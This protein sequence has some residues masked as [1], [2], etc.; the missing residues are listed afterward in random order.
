MSVLSSISWKEKFQYWRPAWMSFLVFVAFDLVLR[1]ILPST[2]QLSFFSALLGT[3]VSLSFWSFWTVV[4]RLLPRRLA[5]VLAFL[6]GLSQACLLI[7]SYFTLSM[8]R[9]YVN[10]YMLMFVT[11]DRGF[12]SDQIWIYGLTPM[13]LGLIPVLVFFIWIWRP[14]PPSAKP[15]PVWVRTVKPAGLMVFF[16]VLFLVALNQVKYETVGQHKWADASFFLALKNYQKSNRLNVLRSSVRAKVTPLTTGRRPDILLFLG[17]SW[18][19]QMMT[20]YGWPTEASP[21]ITR[22][23]EGADSVVMKNAL[24]NSSCTDVSLPSLFAGVGPEE[25]D[26]KLHDMPLIWDW[27]RAAGYTTIFASPQKFAFANFDAFMLS[28]GPDDYLSA[29]R[30]M[31]LTQFMVAHNNGLDDIWAAARTKERIEQ[32]PKDK[33]LLL[34]FFTNATHYPFLQTSSELKEQPKFARPYENSLW[35]DDQAFAVLLEGFRSSRNLTKLWVLTSNDHG[36]LE[37]HVRP[38]PRIASFYDEILGSPMMSRFPSEMSVRWD[39]CQ[40]GFQMNQNRLIQNLDLLPTILDYVGFSESP[41]HQIL[42]S[43]LKGSSLCRPVDPGRVVVGLNTNN[44]RQW[45]PEGFLLA[46]DRWRLVFTNREGLQ[47]FDLRQDPDQ[48]Q[49]RLDEMP[50][51]L[52]EEFRRVVRENLQLQRIQNLYLKEGF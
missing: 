44:I 6:F 28:P 12:I 35:I 24:S 39:E 51:P 13:S 15:G 50:A 27:L 26:Q 41:A 7:A 17:E 25:S 29:D 40:K 21:Q 11:V 47:Y 1:S 16:V 46:K 19:R 30:F 8:L 18:G 10:A 14:I 38:V 3:L 31:S 34:V 2:N 42:Y 20:L 48:K 4:I 52:R 36:E 37:N 45:D 32:A 22:F 43:Q 9:D 23:F 49:N 5:W 33:P